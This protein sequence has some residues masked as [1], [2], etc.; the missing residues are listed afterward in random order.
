MLLASGWIVSSTTTRWVACSTWPVAPF[1]TAAFTTAPTF[2]A[3][4]TTFAYCEHISFYF[5]L[6]Q[7]SAFCAFMVYTVLLAKSC[8][9]I[10]HLAKEGGT[11]R[12][13]GFLNTWKKTRFASP[14]RAAKVLRC[15]ASG[16]VPVERVS[17]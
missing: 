10:I 15:F 5:G 4:G 1:D 7:K 12:E 16:S 17:R 14:A 8:I 13:K 3:A 6:L 11:A 9:Q 2:G